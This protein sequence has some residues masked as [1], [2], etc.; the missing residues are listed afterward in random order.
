MRQTRQLQRENT[1]VSR[2][3][4]SLSSDRVTL[5]LEQK[6]K[7]LLAELEEK[8]GKMEQSNMASEQVWM[9]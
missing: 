6:V 4:L 8:E 9:L 1:E 5:Q 3:Q 7:S 2:S